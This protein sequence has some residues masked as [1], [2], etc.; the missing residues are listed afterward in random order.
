V[1]DD[2]DSGVDVG[3]GF[4]RARVV[5]SDGTEDTITRTIGDRKL[6]VRRIAESVL[7]Y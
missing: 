4:L 5:N 1:S 7:Q 6:A 3:S 2:A